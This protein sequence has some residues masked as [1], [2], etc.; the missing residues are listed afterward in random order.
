MYEVTIKK[1]F[2]AAHRLKEAGGEYEGL[3]GHNFV[4]E[5]TVAGTE[6]DQ[7]DLLIDF[8]ILKKMTN[9]VLDHF[10][11]KYLNE[12]DFF[13]EVN[14]SSEQLARFIFQSLREKLNAPHVKLSRITVWESEDAK[15][16]YY[17]D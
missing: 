9:D 4:V 7:C 11:H 16:T 13:R 15:V 12:M 5:V 10:D 14:P 8:R 2:S 3:H 17:N 1:D 6:L